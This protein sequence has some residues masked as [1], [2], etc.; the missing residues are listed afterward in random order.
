MVEIEIGVM[1]SQ[2]LARRI[3]TK[4]MLI[5]KVNAWE[6]RRNRE[7]ARIKWLFTVERARA[8]LGRAYPVLASQ[9]RNQAAA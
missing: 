4:A 6:R 2:C 1:V 8:K 5:A 7:K 9:N 3:P